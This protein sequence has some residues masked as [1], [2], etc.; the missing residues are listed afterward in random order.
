VVISGV[1]RAEGGQWR[2]WKLTAVSPRLEGVERWPAMKRFVSGGD[3]SVWEL[4]RA[5]EP[6]ASVGDEGVR[7]GDGPASRLTTSGG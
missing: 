4:A 5:P 2:S 1:L 3:S 7:L 6:V